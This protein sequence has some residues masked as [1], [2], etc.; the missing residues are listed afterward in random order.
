[1][2]FYARFCLDTRTYI[3]PEGAD[4]NDRLLNIVKI[5]PPR[6]NEFARVQIFD[7]TPAKLSP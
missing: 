4:L 6:K 7:P 5:Q 3:D 1:M 2:I